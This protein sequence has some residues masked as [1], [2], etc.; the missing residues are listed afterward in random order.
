MTSNTGPCRDP[1]YFLRSAYPLD[2]VQA[3]RA[4]HD[5][6]GAVT[7]TSATQKC[8]NNSVTIT[9]VDDTTRAKAIAHFNSCQQNAAEAQHYHVFEKN[10]GIT[11]TVLGVSAGLGSGIGLAAALI[12]PPI[13][14]SIG[15]CALATTFFGA[16]KIS[17]NQQM[18][19]N[20]EQDR[21]A[22]QHQRDLWRDP[23]YRAVEQRQLAGSQGF[24]YVFNNNLKH[25]IVHPEE[26]K[27]LW[28][29]DFSK[30]LLSSPSVSGFSADLLGKTKL[31]YGWNGAPFHDLE[32]NNRIM[33][34]SLLRMMAT[35]YQECSRD[36]Q[37]FNGKISEENRALNQ[38]HQAVKHEI[39]NQ[40]EIWLQPAYHIHNM[41]VQEAKAL[42]NQAIAQFIRERDLAIAE[43]DQDCNRAL[44]EC[45]NSE[46]ERA[47]IQ[48]IRHEMIAKVRR[49]YDHHPA[50]IAIEEAYKRDSLM[51]SFLF[52]QS[53]M[54]VDSF[55]DQRLHQLEMEVTRS[56]Q[57][58]EQQ[59][60]NGD[61]YFAHQLNQILQGNEESISRLHFT[62]PMINRQWML[63]NFGLEPSWNEVYSNRM[64][65]F[66]STFATTLTEDTWNLFWGDRGIRRFASSPIHSWKSFSPDRSYLP[67]QQRGFHLHSIRHEPRQRMF[68]QR[69]VIPTMTTARAVPG[70]RTTSA[71]DRAQQCPTT[72]PPRAETVRATP[73][74]S[75][76]GTT[77][78]REETASPK[79]ETTRATPSTGF[80][81]TRRREETPQPAK[82]TVRATTGTG[83]G[84]TQ[85]REAPAA[86]PIGETV[87]AQPGVGFG[88]TRRR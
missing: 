30:V 7:Q 75:S 82:E 16:R 51:C 62:P 20:L 27:A 13:A 17:R 85:R 24:S 84:G 42:Y 6:S 18:I 88:G 74:T 5:Y 12:A 87:R 54:M 3:V 79:R 56:R 31:E 60:V 72:P 9:S 8:L 45:L 19:N 10:K 11:A 53:K 14:A 37:Y 38:Q 78:R 26:V 34:A 83:F 40:R 58:I 55:F 41:G 36:Y 80:G 49:E 2:T 1:Q 21:S 15:I 67:F 81:G 23:V 73:G 66:Q 47:Q 29:R 64:P 68:C 69:I 76:G 33:P 50:V 48:G 46:H 77:R 22:F 57:Q 39:A 25:T 44:R 28:I 4:S 32:I 86:S 65:R 70:T 71:F 63:S 59:R 43:I 61:L 52:D 35:R